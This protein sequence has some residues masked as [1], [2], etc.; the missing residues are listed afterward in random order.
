MPP[1]SNCPQAVFIGCGA[2]RMPP[3]I[4]Q[5]G[6]SLCDMLPATDRLQASG[7]EALIRSVPAL[8]GWRRQAVLLCGGAGAVTYHLS[9]E[10]DRG[11]SWEAASAFRDKTVRDLLDAGRPV[12]GKAGFYIDKRLNKHG[13]G[14]TG[15]ALALAQPIAVVRHLMH[16]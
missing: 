6:R 1:A 10:A 8:R 5:F 9:L 7:G 14:Q 3:S 2:A 12:S 4:L 15:R 16:G 13:Q 11:L